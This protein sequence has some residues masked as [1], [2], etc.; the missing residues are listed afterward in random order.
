VGLALRN[1][2]SIS[3]QS[4]AGAISTG[5]HGTG[6]GFGI[7]A[8]DVLEMEL[9]LA[10]TSE[11]T[12]SHQENPDLFKAGLCSLGALGII[13]TVTIRC[14]P[15]FYLD[16]VQYPLPI[17]TLLGEINKIVSSAEHVRIWW[18]PHTEKCIVWQANRTEPQHTVPPK[19]LLKQLN[20]IK[21][22]LIG[23]YSLEFAYYV[24]TYNDTMI[25]Y[26]NKVYRRLLYNKTKASQDLSYKVFNFD[27]ILKQH[28]IE[29][30]IPIENLHQAISTLKNMINTKKYRVHFPIEIRFV[31]GD[32]IWLSPAYGGDRACIGI[33]MYKPY[34]R[35]PP[36]TNYFHE[37][38][39]KMTALGGRPHW[40]KYHKW[41]RKEC[42]E[43]Y[44]KFKDFLSLREKLDPTKL[45]NN[46]YL[47]QIFKE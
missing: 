19:N 1:L 26:V 5:T 12:C 43:A 4:V 36:Y 7:L 44:P 17:D 35:E 42:L 9:I 30:S 21:D 14:E 46:E 22:Q 20:D 16:T 47:Q 34:G 24:S 18:F 38:E 8:S 41:T 6:I 31:K 33:M 3:D 23:Y 25:P 39:S 37:F 27:N 2:G 13:S 40:G 10:N 28:N 29:C 32:D 15:V 45:F 11:I